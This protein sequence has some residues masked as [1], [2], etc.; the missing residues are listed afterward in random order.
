MTAKDIELPVIPCDTKPQA[1]KGFSF[2]REF[3]EKYD[4]QELYK[5]LQ[6]R[7]EEDWTKWV[8]RFE[9]DPSFFNAWRYVEGHPL[10]WRF[11]AP[12]N[13]DA[14]FHEEFLVHDQGVA[15]GLEIQVVHVNPEDDRISDDEAKNT[16]V[17]IW[18]EVMP[19]LL[20]PQSKHRIHAYEADGGGKT[21]EA[22]I[23]MA[24]QEI[25]RVYGNDRRVLDEEFGEDMF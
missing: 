23:V 20:G 1:G 2:L 4:Y 5:K 13:G 19:C 15:E 10:F 9:E 6:E 21:Y 8:Q 3:M 11:E 17:R 18:Y 24:A 12:S 14:W 25:H 16:A 22:A 7:R